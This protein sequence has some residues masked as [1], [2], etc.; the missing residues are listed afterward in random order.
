MTNKAAKKSANTACE[1]DEH[2]VI[3]FSL[4]LRPTVF[5]YLKAPS[6]MAIL[7]TLTPEDMSGDTDTAKGLLQGAGKHVSMIDV[8]PHI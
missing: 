2:S 5:S 4:R 7:S 3:S 1:W 6:T 8:S